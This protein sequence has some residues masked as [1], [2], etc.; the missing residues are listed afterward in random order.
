MNKKLFLAAG[1]AAMAGLLWFAYGRGD[2][3]SAQPAPAPTR[4]EADTLRYAADAPQLSMIRSEVLS[5][6]PVPLGETLS[7]RLV[8]D[9]DATARIGMGVSGRIVAIHVAAGDAVKA[10]QVLADIDSPDFGAARADLEKARA[11]E[12]RKQ[13]EVERARQ[14]EPGEAISERDWEA[15][16]ADLAQA[17]AETARAEQRLKN[18]NPQGLAMHGQRLRLTSPIGGVVTERSASPALEVEPGMAEPLFVVTDPTRLWLLIDLPE[19]LL[20]RVKRGSAVEVESDAWPGERFAGKVLETGQ[21]VDANTRRI[22]VRARVANPGRKLLPEM[23]V[24]VH[25]LQDEGRGVR[26]PNSALVN[27]G[28]YSSVFVQTG[29]AEFRR[30]RVELLTHGAEFSCVGAGLKG[31]EH[32]VTGGA[33]L[34]DAELNA[35]AGGPS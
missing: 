13:L 4:A 2:A 23:F 10:G 34:L 21:R 33:L 8:Y 32:V 30:Q 24:R 20:A 9:D 19:P 25:I 26:V 3:V 6:S 27:Q 35:R 28:I 15:L 5:S 31:G 17:Q 29:P 22:S 16:Q 7:G 1:V 12:R 14:L 18:L 11:D